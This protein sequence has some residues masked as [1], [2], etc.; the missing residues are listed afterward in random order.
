MKGEMNTNLKMRHQRPDIEKVLY[1]ACFLNTQFKTMQFLEGEKKELVHEYVVED[2]MKHIAQDV[3]SVDTSR[4]SE[5]EDDEPPP[6][7]RTWQT[8]E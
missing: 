1:L 3:E 5:N 2:V 4:K 8:F 7:N 6:K